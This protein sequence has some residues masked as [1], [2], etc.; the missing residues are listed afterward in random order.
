MIKLKNKEKLPIIT[1]GGCHNAQFNV[2]MMNIPK[3]ISEY[4]LSGYFFERPFRFY[5]MEWVPRCF[6][7]WLVFKNNGGA[8]ASIGNTGLGIGYVNEYWN[9]GLSGW[10]MPRFYGCYTNQSKNILGEAHDQAIT[11]YIQIIGG[12]NSQHADRKTIEEWLL[13]GDPS[14]KIG[15]Y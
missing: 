11:D 13:I 4:G 12:V 1:V 15:G 8:I 9:E 3:G 2:T 14:L 7:T 10:L 6:C 5:Y